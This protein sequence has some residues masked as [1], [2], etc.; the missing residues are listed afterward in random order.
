MNVLEHHVI[1]L[2]GEPE[3][4][5]IELKGSPAVYCATQKVRENCYGRE[6]ISKVSR[7]GDTKEEVLDKISEVKE[8]YTYLS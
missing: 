4:K 3:V 6:S 8:G 2:I 7:Y 5:V 1:E